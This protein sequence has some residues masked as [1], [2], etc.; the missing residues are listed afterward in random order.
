MI[1]VETGLE[2]LEELNT[3]VVVEE[4]RAESELTELDAAEVVETATSL[5]LE[6]LETVVVVEETRAESELTGLDAAEVVEAATSLELEELETVVV[7]EETR[8][9]PE[10]TELDAAAGVEATVFVT[11]EVATA[12][13]ACLLTRPVR[14]SKNRGFPVSLVAATS[15]V[16]G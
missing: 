11:V 7:V 9:D 3:V 15:I 2:E 14:R 16:E 1:E 13:P 5:E 8:A 10:L 12:A 6:E 4:T